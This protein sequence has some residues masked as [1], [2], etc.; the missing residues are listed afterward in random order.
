[1]IDTLSTEMSDAVVVISKIN[2]E[3]HVTELAFTSMMFGIVQQCSNKIFQVNLFLK[4][5]LFYKL[6]YSFR[7]YGKK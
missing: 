7:W 5:F 3:D 1:M 2:L 6:K 4:R